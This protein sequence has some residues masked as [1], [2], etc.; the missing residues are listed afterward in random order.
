M[1]PTK[2]SGK[3]LPAIINL[4]L[5]FFTSREVRVPTVRES[6][7]NAITPIAYPSTK[8]IPPRL[9]LQKVRYH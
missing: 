2:K 4:L 9:Y 8:V 3:L 7:K 5:L 6:A 1:V